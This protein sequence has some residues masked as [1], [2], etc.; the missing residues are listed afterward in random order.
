MRKITALLAVFVMIVSLA[1]C[2]TNSGSTQATPTAA[3]TEVPTE[4][5]APTP[6]SVDEPTEA[7]PTQTPAAPEVT[8]E[9]ESGSNI[10]IAY[11]SR[12]GNM[13]YEEGVDATTSASVNLGDGLTGN[14]E[15]LA[16]MAQDVT[17][18]DLF[19][20]E[21]V[22]K[23]PA[24][25]RATTD[26]AKAEQNNADRPE[27]ASHV[28]N[29]DSYD[30]VILIYPNWWG[31]LPMPVFTFLGEYD[32]SGKTILP[33]CTH[34]GSGLSRTESTIANL[35]PEATVLDGLS[36]RGGNAASAQAD[37]ENWIASSG[38]LS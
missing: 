27:L 31:D 15:L 18:G 19:F 35:F 8:D 29:M 36:V 10:L 28:E 13:N 30:T 4:A 7:E 33:L 38:I 1:A 21:T 16:H 17:G 24:Q 37:V 26:Q 23:Y 34:E 25:Y 14:A 11:F 6:E 2:G 12:V 3:P 32:F 20:I 5:P 22:D 9:P